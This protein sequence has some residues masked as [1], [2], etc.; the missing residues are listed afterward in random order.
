MDTIELVPPEGAEFALYI[1][2]EKDVGNPQRIFRAAE[3][4]IWAFHKLDKVLCSAID[5][6]I[7]PLLILREIE[8]GSLRIWLA[9]RLVS[10]DDQALKDLDWK[11]LVGKYLVRAKYLYIDWANQG[12]GA[13][14]SDLRAGLRQL[15]AE[16]DV[17]HIPA[18][19]EPAA[20]EL[21]ES[22]GNMEAAKRSLG[23]KDR[24]SYVTR[25]DG[26]KEIDLSVSWSADQISD[27]AT[28]ETV[29]FP[30]APMTLIVKKPD[31]LGNSKW[32]FRHGK[33]PILA[34]IDDSKWLTSFQ[35]REVDVRPGDALRCQVLIEHG[36]G[37]DN[38]LIYERYTVVHVDEVLP[39]AASPK[40]LFD[41]Q[42][43]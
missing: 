16:T 4:M 2:F 37:Y 24:M 31:Y 14:L 32:D 20:Q 9:N 36:Y 18:Y 21:L 35:S 19:S 33:H 27:T 34:K 40:T 39:S 26:E 43:Q 13:R 17:R 1:D 15:A 7:E 25:T 6:E 5:A 28:K 30:P 8:T 12:G 3:E 10:V 41:D 38:E 29:R 22:L 42:E 23:T 11:P